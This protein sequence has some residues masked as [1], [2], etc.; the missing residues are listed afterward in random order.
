MPEL[1]D[2]DR[3]VERLAEQM[4]LTEALPTLAVDDQFAALLPEGITDDL[5]TSATKQPGREYLQVNSQRRVKFRIV[6]PV[7]RASA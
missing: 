5:Q 3:L 7:G 1:T 4:K 6:A 2:I